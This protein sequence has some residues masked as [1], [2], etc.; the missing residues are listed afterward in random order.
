MTTGYDNASLEAV[1]MT[2][3]ANNGRSGRAE[4]HLPYYYT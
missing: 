3:R 1:E 4:N 2:S